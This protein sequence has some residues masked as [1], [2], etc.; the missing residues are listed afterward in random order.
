MEEDKFRARINK[1]KSQLTVD[2]IVNLV[3]EGLGAGPCKYDTQG[4]PIFATV[5]HNPDGGG[6]HKLYYYIDTQ[7]FVCYTNCGSFDVFELVKKVKG[8]SGFSEAYYWVCN[9]FGLINAPQRGFIP[10]CVELTPDWDLLN[11]IHDY[12]ENAEEERVNT[13][14]LPEGLLNYYFV[15]YPLEWLR[16]GITKEAMDKYD[17]R[18]DIGAQKIIIPHRDGEGNLIGIRG[19]SYNVFDLDNGKKYMPAF[20]GERM[21]N[22]P[23]GGFL[24]GL[25]KNKDVI[26]RL[27][28]VCIFESEKSVL[29]TEGYYPGNNFSVATCG[30]AGLSE[31]QIRELMQLGVREIIF[32]YDREN[33]GDPNSDKTKEYEA[34]LLRIAL[35][36]T[37]YFEVSVLFD[38]SPYILLG[39]KDSPADR[40][41]EVLEALM[42]KKIHIQNEEVKE[43]EKTRRKGYRER[44]I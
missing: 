27:G 23:L 43:I 37:V 1:I 7:T 12:Q 25:D 9:Y 15:G 17:I 31:A 33:D 42:R 6:S 13:E 34:K 22:H 2:D 14:I 24:Y 11:K 41:K 29:L 18:I 40:G 5:C 38:Y 10:P 35:P 36:L 26:S 8:F 4:N 3:S 39:P 21:F 30:S 20:M 28:K 44:K 32:A 16:E 19:R